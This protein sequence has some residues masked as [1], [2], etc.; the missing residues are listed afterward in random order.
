MKDVDRPVSREVVAEGASKPRN[1]QAWISLWSAIGAVV[2][3]LMYQQ[4]RAAVLLIAV[5]TAAFLATAY[6]I[7]GLIRARRTGNGLAKAL[8]GL[9]V[10]IGVLVAA[11][12]VGLA[13]WEFSRSNWHF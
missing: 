6:G 13:L 12:V 4:E 3:L 1:L 10:G 11:G 7:V 2:L 5:P 8:V 9:L